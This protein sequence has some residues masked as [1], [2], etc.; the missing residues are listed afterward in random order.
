MSRNGRASLAF[1]GWTVVGAGAVLGAL[2]MLSIGIFVLPGTALLAGFLAWRGHG[3]G[4]R[5]I[6]PSVLTGAGI[7]PLYVAYL[8][9]GGPGNVCTTWATGGSCTQ[10]TSPWPWVAAG[11]LMGTGGVT[12]A[13]MLRRTSTRQLH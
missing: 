8:N 1:L 6:G 11:L 3:L 4:G 13:L 10:E 7:I 2:T 5:L 9:R 12:L